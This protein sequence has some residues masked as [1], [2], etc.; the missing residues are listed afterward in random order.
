MTSKGFLDDLTT[1]YYCFENISMPL[2]C[3]KRDKFVLVVQNKSKKTKLKGYKNAFGYSTLTK[4]KTDMNE[5]SEKGKYL[6]SI[7]K[8]YAVRQKC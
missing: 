3:E 6:V 8:L 2:I 4:A 1:K 7:H 5:K